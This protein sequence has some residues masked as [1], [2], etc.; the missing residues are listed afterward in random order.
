M[1]NEAQLT[2]LRR[3]CEEGLVSI[4]LVAPDAIAGA[5]WDVSPADFLDD[6]LGAVYA[7]IGDLTDAGQEV[8]SHAVLVEAKRR[9]L[10]D[11]LTSSYIYRLVCAGYAPANARYYAQTVKRLARTRRIVNAAR[12][13]VQDEYAT[14]SEP[15][16]LLDRFEAATAG[17][18]TDDDAGFV[19]FADAVTESICEHRAALEGNA[20]RFGTG[21][22]SLDAIVGGFCPGQ[23]ILLGGRTFAGKTALA[24]SFASYFATQN[25]A[26]WFVSLEMNRRELAER[27]LADDCGY[28]LRQFTQFGLTLEQI[29]A[30]NQ[31]CQHY[32]T[33]PLVITDH[34]AESVRTIRAKAKLRKSQGLDF[35]V[36]DNLQLVTP[37]DPKE[38]RRMQLESTSRELKRLAKELDCVVLLLCQLNADAEGN[39]PDD[40]HYS[41]SKQILSHADLAMLAHRASKTDSDFLLKITKNRR[42]KPDRLTLHF[43]GAY[44]RF[45]DPVCVVGEEWRP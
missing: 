38:P 24:L 34:P 36:L 16:E 12:K 6:D 13:I 18:L 15:A 39:E 30:I 43:D 28:E 3:E 17:L 29:E 9:G 19:T 7:I 8:E 23:L 25:R 31:S 20:R 41:E 10:I 14:D 32:A 21:F 45:Q 22:P 5:Y 26:T 40:R 42:G 27:L 37:S 1:S 35:I 11:Q 33:L 2:E 44:Q 4:A